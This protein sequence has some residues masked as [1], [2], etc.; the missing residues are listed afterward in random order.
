MAS[1]SC[2][3]QSFRDAKTNTSMTRTSRRKSTKRTAVVV[4]SMHRSGTS[5]LTRVLGLLGCT[6]PRTLVAPR[7]NDNDAGF[8]ESQAVVDVNAGICESA[9]SNWNDWIPLSQ[10]WLSS[11]V[12]GGFVDQ[13]HEVLEQEFGDSRLFVLKDPR[14]CRLMPVWAEA[15]DRFGARSLFVLPV[16][17]PL[18]VSASLRKRNQLLSDDSHLAWLRHML[19]AERYSRGQ[20]RVYTRYADLVDNWR[21]TVERISTNLD[22][23]W[24]NKSAAVEDEVDA[25]LDRDLRHHEV[26]DD[27]VFEEA[28]HSPWIRQCFDILNRWTRDEFLENDVETLDRVNAEINASIPSFGRIVAEVRTLGKERR[29]LVKQ[30]NAT[31]AVERKLQEAAEAAERKLREAETGSRAEIARL[32]DRSA[33]ADDALA[34]GKKELS[35]AV[36][37]LESQRAQIKERDERLAA[38][39]LVISEHRQAASAVQVE[40]GQSE[41][42]LRI[43]RAELADSHDRLSR[44]DSELAR[45]RVELEAAKSEMDKLR[46]E[47]KLRDERLDVAVRK[48]LEALGA[49]QVELGQSEA[50]L[51]IARAELAD[52][53][54]RLSRTN[55]A[56]AEERA[57]LAS[58]K[59]ELGKLR[60]EL[61]E[62]DARWDVAVRK[63]REVLE[64]LQLEL[65]QSEANLR[66]ARS[67]VAELSN[68]LSGS[69]SMLAQTR[70]ELGSAREELDRLRAEV[71]E[72]DERLEVADA[73]LRERQ[74]ALEAARIELGGS[75]AD[76][77]AARVE[78]EQLRGKLG[79]R[80]GQLRSL[81]MRRASELDEARLAIHQISQEV[82]DKLGEQESALEAARSEIDALGTLAR[83]TEAQLVLLRAKREREKKKAAA[84]HAALSRNLEEARRRSTEAVNQAKALLNDHMRRV[85]LELRAPEAG[86]FSRLYP[87]RRSRAMEHAGQLERIAGEL[88]DSAYFDAEWYLA[89]N[90]DVAEAGVDP[91]LHFI[92]YGFQEGRAPNARFEETQ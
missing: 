61:R 46:G 3:E 29:E 39:D 37:K 79:E 21:R 25:F 63:H 47:L 38:M 56:L 75:E 36:A 8:W 54:D 53:R 58:T 87:L 85:L 83:E 4:L 50:N 33:Q 49:A 23:A 20:P 15:L 1:C 73:A 57:E 44:T 60:G 84:A 71:K 30:L 66:A 51:R 43:A 7:K 42:N 72:R 59:G 9:G 41:A 86:V 24:P 13:A 11:P 27:R 65:G 70:T 68:R 26:E 45:K 64:A 92:Q 2:L 80:D 77:R 88:R 10:E 17:N 40:L 32:R 14:L 28:F 78:L 90:P 18:E 67:E 31:N 52:S 22:L 69:E 34:Q 12:K 89:R 62:R 74:E 35:E 81:E 6:L 82:S 16:R 76:L 19:D 91:A 55:N 48:H 5:A